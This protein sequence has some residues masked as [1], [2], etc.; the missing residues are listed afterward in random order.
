[1]HS[2]FYPIRLY[3]KLVAQRLNSRKFA[4]FQVAFD[5][6]AL[7]ML[8]SKTFF[9]LNALYSLGFW[10]PILFA[11]RCPSAVL[12]NTDKMHGGDNLHCRTPFSKYSPDSVF[13]KG[14]HTTC[15]LVLENSKL[16]SCV[17]LSTYVCRLSCKSEMKAMV[18]SSAK[19]GQ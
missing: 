10:L 2:P 18:G 5:R 3:W 9:V 8:V 1:M 6:E 16:E 7:R 12:S 17:L 11:P 19:Q 14:A 15:F 13:G 4:C